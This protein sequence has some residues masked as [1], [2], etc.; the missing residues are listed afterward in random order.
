MKKYSFLLLSLLFLCVFVHAQH[1]G[2]GYRLKTIVPVAGRQGVAVDENF[3][4]VSDSKALYKYDKF[5]KLLTENTDPFTELKL[6]VNHIGD[7]DVWK[8]ELFCGMEYFDDG[9]G[10]NIQIAVFDASTLRF[11]R[12]IEWDDT[13]GQVEVSGLAVDRS[14]NM[15]WLSDWVNSRYVYCYDLE[16]GKYY[17]KMQCRP[18]P[19]WCQGL[20]IADQKMLFSA[21]DGEAAFQIADC[22]YRADISEIPFYGIVNGQA[23]GAIGGHLRLFREMKD[24]RRTGEIEGLSIDPSTDD[25]VVLNNRGVR[26]VNGMPKEPFRSEGYTHEIHELYI[27][28]KIK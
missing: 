3:Y 20:F 22:I 8:G 17:T 4:Y 5:G 21:D 19:Y 6:A 25:L 26:I 13:S 10:K 24:F 16:T 2:K 11:K 18:A 7:I 1:I 12:S 23:S 9:H 27:Y 28:E 15:V 14:R